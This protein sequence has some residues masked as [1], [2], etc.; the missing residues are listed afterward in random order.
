MSTRKLVSVSVTRNGV[1]TKIPCTQEVADMLMSKEIDSK[2]KE[3][4]VN[5]LMLSPSTP[6]STGET[7]MLPSP[8]TPPLPGPSTPSLPGPS[9]PSL[10]GPSKPSLP[11]PS[12]PSLPGPQTP[13]LPGPS[14]QD[15]DTNEK[16]DVQ[17]IKL[18]KKSFHDIERTSKPLKNK[19]QKVASEVNRVGG[20][21]FS[22]E[23]CRLKIKGLKS[24]YER[25]KKKNNTSGESP[26]SDEDDEDF[27]VFEKIP[28]MKPKAVL[29]S[30]TGT[31]KK[32]PAADD[33]S[34]EETEPLPVKKRVHPKR[35]AEILQVML[36]DLMEK[37]EEKA[38]QRHQEKLATANSLIEVL[39]EL[40]KNNFTG[41]II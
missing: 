29:E 3:I 37:R 38:E 20:Y 27:D 18:L 24:K 40:A 15:E 6:P 1:T 39:K 13:S 5:E 9:T 35:S 4:I 31:S 30:G 34:S 33:S 23:K 7:S 17:S 26:A 10:P 32:R 22:A 14:A 8:S 36:K 11:G 25:Q 16:W 12:K 28:D 19:W 41:S 2:V 21:S